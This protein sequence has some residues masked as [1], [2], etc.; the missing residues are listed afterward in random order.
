LVRPELFKACVINYPF[1]DV[2]NCLLDNEQ[3][4][5]ASDY[6]EFGN[7]LEKEFFYDLISSYSPYENIL[8]D[9]EYPAVYITCGT[10]DHRAP[11]WN[12]LKYV[13]RFR[14]RAAIPKRIE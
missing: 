5:S 13:K 10:N 11:L 14:D 6:D 12:V 8:E 1:L 9:V 7:P 3:A 4:L 2:L